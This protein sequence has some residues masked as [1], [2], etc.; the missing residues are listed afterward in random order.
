MP[1]LPPQGPLLLPPF[2]DKAAH[3][4]QRK[5]ASS[6]IPSVPHVLHLF[7]TLGPAVLL[8]LAAS[9][10][11]LNS[12]NSALTVPFASHSLTILATSLY[13]F[14]VVLFLRFSLLSP[15]RFF[16]MAVAA[17]RCPSSDRR[18]STQSSRAYCQ[19]SRLWAVSAL[20][21]HTE[22]IFQCRE[23]AGMVLPSASFSS[24]SPPSSSG[25][26]EGLLLGTA[27]RNLGWEKSL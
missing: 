22:P 10:I 2:R 13:F 26:G 19:C 23:A 25:E 14:F 5:H 1:F 27:S 24:G 16:E 21:W 15:S 4:L 8:F 3:C 12:R 20:E 18:V 11:S 9:S 17:V 7:C 6:Y